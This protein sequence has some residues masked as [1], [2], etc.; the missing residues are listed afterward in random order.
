MKE[1][2]LEQIKQMPKAI[3]HIHLDGSLRP[4]TVYGWLKE[5]G[6]DISLE[7]VRNQLMVDRDCRDLNQYLT[8]FGLPVSVLQ[9]ED[10][11][12]S[13]RGGRERS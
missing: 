1:E 10:G 8:K 4:E 7:E 2:M 12:F 3:L 6:I 13:P 11:S 5:Q 9:N